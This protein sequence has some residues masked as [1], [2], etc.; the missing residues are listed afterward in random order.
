[1]RLMIQTQQRGLVLWTDNI[2]S[3]S[4]FIKDTVLTTLLFS[5]LQ[6][7]HLALI[8]M[9]MMAY[10]VEMVSVE[11]V[12][13]CIDRCTSAETSH[14][15]GHIQELPYDTEDA[16]TTWINKVHVAVM[17]SIHFKIL[18]SKSL[19][20]GSS[21]YDSS[22]LNWFFIY[23]TLFNTVFSLVSFTEIREMHRWQYVCLLLWAVLADRT[24]G[25]FRTKCS[26][27]CLHTDSEQKSICKNNRFTELNRASKEIFEVVCIVRSSLQS[28]ECF[29]I[30]LQLH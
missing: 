27:H 23:C 5:V 9:L 21:V 14:M 7:S 4:F 19:Y 20:T 8:D 6:S 10:T 30:R 26:H 13:S 24:F 28:A 15:D 16:I 11:R 18:T 25:H 3:S 2:R 12:M 22:V 1:M 17:T 29:S